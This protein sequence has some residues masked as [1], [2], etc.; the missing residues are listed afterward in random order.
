MIQIKIKYT[1]K[2][3]YPNNLHYGFRKVTDNGKR[4]EEVENL[5]DVDKYYKQQEAMW[6]EIYK[7]FK[8][9]WK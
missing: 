7:T 6:Q 8:E 9:L 4:L 2:Y 3:E 5:I 1:Q